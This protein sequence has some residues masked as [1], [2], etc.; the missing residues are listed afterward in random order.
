MEQRRLALAE[1]GRN[2]ARYLE[3]GILIDGARNQAG[4]FI[5]AGE[6]YG[7]R[8]RERGRRLDS[9]KTNLSNV[10]A[11]V[12]AKSAAN[13]VERALFLDTA[14]V[15]VHVADVVEVRKYKRLFGVKA[16]RDDILKERKNDA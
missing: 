10:V 11:L 6:R 15:G 5:L 13:L 3:I 7:K 16:A 1:A 9:R 12:D 2:V 14:D 4:H 8:R